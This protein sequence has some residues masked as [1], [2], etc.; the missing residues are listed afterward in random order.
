MTLDGAVEC[1]ADSFTQRLDA[2]TRLQPRLGIPVAIEHETACVE[3]QR[4]RGRQQLDS[5]KETLER[6]DVLEREQLDEGVEIQLG[7]YETAGNER[8]DLRR[9]RKSRSVPDVIEGFHAKPVPGDEQA[10]PRLVPEREREH[11]VQL[12]YELRPALFVEMHDGLRVG[13]RPEAVSCTH[14]PVTEAG[15]VVDLAVV[16]EADGL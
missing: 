11:A 1:H 10:L 14:Q 5:A 16:D 15:R 4:G 12:F 8:P 7:L 9:E 3:H 6:D 13:A 2:E